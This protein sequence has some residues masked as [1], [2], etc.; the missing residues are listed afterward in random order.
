MRPLPRHAVNKQATRHALSAEYELPARSP[1]RDQRIE[2]PHAWSDDP[3][4]RLDHLSDRAQL[5]LPDDACGQ[6]DVATAMTAPAPLRDRKRQPRSRPR[7][8]SQETAL[9]HAAGAASGRVRRSVAGFPA[10]PAHRSAQTD[11]AGDVHRQHG[12]QARLARGLKVRQ[13]QPARPRMLVIDGT[14]TPLQRAAEGAEALV[15][16]ALCKLGPRRRPVDG[17]GLDVGTRALVPGGARL[18]RRRQHTTAH[19]SSRQLLHQGL[20]I[21]FRAADMRRPVP[22]GRL[23]DLGRRRHAR[24]ASE[25]NVCACR[26]PTA[27][28]STGAIR[29]WRE[30]GSPSRRCAATAS[31]YLASSARNSPRPARS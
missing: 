28:A 24:P 3:V 26:S 18:V 11:V 9:L 31:K 25:S 21:D 20:D 30:V 29:A 4:R 19:P 13:P 6:R 2:Q 7:E 1:T 12:A 10:E 27:R 23:H 14:A 17:I 22:R 15:R 16:R 5:L 8:R